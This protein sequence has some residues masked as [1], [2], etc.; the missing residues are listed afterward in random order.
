PVP[1]LVSE[2]F[3]G[4][5]P[6][7]VAVTLYGPPAMP[8]AVNGADATPEAFVATVMVVVLLLNRPLAPD[9]GAVKVTLNPATGLFPPSF[10]VTA[11]AFG[12]VVLT[13]VDCGVV[14]GL[15]VIV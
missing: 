2:K 10:P 11:R 4:A 3:T 12:K 6:D 14:P 1:V 8:L 9:P 13:G 7:P 5:T 15:A